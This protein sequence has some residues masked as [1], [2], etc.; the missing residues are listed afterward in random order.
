M[1]DAIAKRVETNRPRGRSSSVSRFLFGAYKAVVSP[2]LHAI[3]PSRCRYL[4][5]CSEYAYVAV[6]RFGLFRGTWLA[7]RRIVRCHPWAD[8]GL[9]PV[10]EQTSLP[11]HGNRPPDHLP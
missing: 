10:P 5:T 2:L 6:S 4:P 8:G 9:D 11:Q 1:A 7:A 3:A